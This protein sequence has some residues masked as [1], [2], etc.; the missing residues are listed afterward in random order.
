MLIFE[1]LS[2]DSELFT[3]YSKHMEGVINFSKYLQH[4]LYTL[5]VKSVNV[6]VAFSL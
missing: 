3:L 4:V 1:N 2:I 6:H 5:A